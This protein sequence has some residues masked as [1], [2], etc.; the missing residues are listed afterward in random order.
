MCGNWIEEDVW[1]RGEGQEGSWEKGWFGGKFASFPKGL[2][3]QV[4]VLIFL[5]TTHVLIKP[6][7]VLK[8]SC[9]I[10]NFCSFLLPG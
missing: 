6:V 3:P 10:H 9:A 5:I 1:G 7:N 2:S 4:G 8:V